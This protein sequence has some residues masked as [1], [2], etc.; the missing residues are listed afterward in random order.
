[1]TSVAAA[2]DVAA[3]HHRCRLSVGDHDAVVANDEA[4]VW[5]ALH[6]IGVAPGADFGERDRF[7]REI[8]VEA[9]YVLA[10][11]CSYSA[12]G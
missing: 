12:S 5:I 6:R 3:R 8:P 11:R 10:I 9:K 1:M 7:L 2:I 4:G